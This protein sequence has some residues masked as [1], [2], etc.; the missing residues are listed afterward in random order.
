MKTDSSDR[1]LDPVEVC[2]LS[3]DQLAERSKWI[4]S[5]ILAR[6]LGKRR[7]DFGVAVEIA[8]SPGMRERIDHWIEL[9]GECCSS[10]RFERRESTE[11]GCVRVEIPGVDPDATFLDAL[12]D[13]DDDVSSAGPARPETP[14]GVGRFLRAGGI[15]ALASI[16]T[17]C[18]LPMLLVS[19]L[20][21]LFGGVAASV[22]L[23]ALDDPLW[24]GLGTLVA[25]TG[26]WWWTGR[27]RH[28][29]DE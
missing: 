21:A 13:L 3:P 22:P 6:A 17:F 16:F 23:A 20:G 19:V 9:E 26:V 24:I 18:V 7:T 28:A 1:L 2:T 8:D 15:G 25:A 27:N 11:P 4:R 29:C 12:P 14:G 5:E 10:I